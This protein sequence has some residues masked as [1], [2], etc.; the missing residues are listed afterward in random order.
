MIPSSPAMAAAGRS[1]LPTS[2]RSCRISNFSKKDFQAGRRSFCRQQ[3]KPGGCRSSSRQSRSMRSPDLRY[4]PQSQHIKGT[5][6]NNNIVSID[7]MDRGQQLPLRVKGPL[8][9]AGILFLQSILRHSVFVGG[10]NNGSFSGPPICCSWPS[11][12]TLACGADK[13]FRASWVFSAEMS[14]ENPPYLSYVRNIAIVKSD[15]FIRQPP[16]CVTLF[17]SSAVS[18]TFC[19]KTRC[20][21]QTLQERILDKK[22]LSL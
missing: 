19:D 13:F 5:L 7:L 15:H 8:R 1:Y 17:L 11:R 21:S 3:P 4:T 12:I 18:V 9:Q 10:K 6:D 14:N 22:L 16:A 20:L 2:C